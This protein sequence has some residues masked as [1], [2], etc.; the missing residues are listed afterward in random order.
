MRILVTGGA[1]CIGSNLAERLLGEGHTVIALDNLSA[2]SRTFLS[3]CEQMARF[4][5][6]CADLLNFAAL[7]EAMADVEV[8]F[9]LAANSDITQSR[10]QTDLDLRLGTLATFNVLEAMRL[11]GVSKIIF[12]SSSVVYGEPTVM[13]TPEDYGPLF[14]I[15]FYGASKL[16]A[17]ALISAYCRNFGFQAWIYRFANICGR[18]GTHGVIVDFIRKLQRDPSRLQVLG[19]GKQAKPYLH[20][21]ECVDGMLYGWQHS[22][23]ALNYFNLGCDGSTSVTR[24][25]QFLLDAMDLKGAEIVCTGGQRGWSGDVPQVR[26][27]CGKLERMGWK[28][29]LTSDAAVK[30]AVAELVKELNCRPLALS[31]SRES[32]LK[33]NA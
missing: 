9:H 4:R 31:T 20:V 17:E 1:G 6:I 23:A 3:E 19:D 14:P 26:L 32:A 11:A 18:H 27:D 28:A 7:R 12:S 25:A 29:K 30:L 15:S 21:G 5:F 24:L 33:S 16:A 8:V 22:T 10:L 13:P 2:G